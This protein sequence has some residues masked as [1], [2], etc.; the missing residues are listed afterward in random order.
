M[1][2]NPTKLN[3]DKAVDR[4]ESKR[5][6]INIPRVVKKHAF[7]RNSASGLRSLINHEIKVNIEAPPEWA[8]PKGRPRKY[9]HRKLIFSYTLDEMRRIRKHM[10]KYRNIY[11]SHRT[12]L[13][14]GTINSFKRGAKPA[15][16]TLLLLFILDY[17]LKIFPLNKYH[18]GLID[19]L[20]HLEKSKGGDMGLPLLKR[21]DVLRVIYPMDFGYSRKHY[22]KRA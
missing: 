22:T 11:L 16:G 12:G 19:S 18:A 5:S 2:A 10:L 20:S 21:T 14:I 15:E 6:S 13:S 8:P 4:Y 7:K 17:E 1:L 9:K 3:I